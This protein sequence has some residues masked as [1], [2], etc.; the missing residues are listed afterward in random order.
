ME[1]QRPMH[2]VDH[3][4]PDAARL[5]FIDQLAVFLPAVQGRQIDIYMWSCYEALAF[6]RRSIQV[7]VLRLG[8]SPTAS[9]PR[10]VDR[11][12]RQRETT[13]GTT[14]PSRPITQQ[15]PI[16]VPR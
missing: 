16:S 12:F 10:L 8:W 3:R 4:Q 2:F 6:G 14:L 15:G 1:F 7:T 5:G 11:L 9:S 13:Q